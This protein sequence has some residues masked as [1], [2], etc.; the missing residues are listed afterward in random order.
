MLSSSH[1]IA[2]LRKGLPFSGRLP[3][4]PGPPGERSERSHV[5]LFGHRNPHRLLKSLTRWTLTL[6]LTRRL[7][8][9]HLF[10]VARALPYVRRAL[11]L[12][13]TNYC[14]IYPGVGNTLACLART[15]SSLPR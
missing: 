5:R 11:N 3:A 10:H 1:P 4:A 12:I 15:R 13:C 9:P 14:M 7:T 6:L 8:P 2:R